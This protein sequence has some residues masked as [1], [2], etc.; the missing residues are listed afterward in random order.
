[1]GHLGLMKTKHLVLFSLLAWLEAVLALLAL[2][3]MVFTPGRGGTF[4]Y[5]LMRQVLSAGW[6]VFLLV[7]AIFTI[8]LF[9]RPRWGTVLV[10]WLDDALI[11]VKKRLFWVQFWL[12]LAALFLFECFLI[13]Y[14][15]FPE[16]A[17]P[18]L[19]WATLLCA[20]AWVALR[21]VYAGEY[22]SR[23]SLIARI[24]AK[25]HAWMPIQ[26]KTFI[27]L[28]ILS[29]IYFAAFI[30]A[31]SH[32]DQSGNFYVHQD[33]QVVYPEVV[34]DMVFPPTVS[35]M[36]H[37]VLEGWGWQY[38]YPYFTASAAVLLIPRLVYGP[39]FAAHIRLNLFLL[40]QFIDVLPMTLAILLVV[41][42]ATRFKNLWASV[43]AF[44]FMALL[45][46]VVKYNIRFY[47]PDALIVL[48]MVLGIYGL[49]KDDLR[50]GRYFYL[51][52][53]CCGLAA[54]IK[55][56]GLFFGPL[57][58]A[59]LLAGWIKKRLS[60]GGL[61]VKGG[62][63]VLAMLA[64]AVISTPTL[65]APYIARVALRSWL[66]RQGYLLTGYPVPDPTGDYG[67]GLVNW[68]RFF[69]AHYMKG[70]YF[71]FSFLALLAG[72]L[73]GSRKSLNR[74]LLGLC[75]VIAIFLAYVVA[76]KNLQYMLPLAL[77]L[78]A[79]AFLFPS[80]AEPGPGSNRPVF[81]ARPL[82]ARMIQMVT[83]C[84]VISQ[85][86][87]NLVILGLFIIRGQ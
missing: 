34:K 46:G 66:P 73:W 20:Q 40:R 51:A 29:L 85:F 14:L 48:L 19:L 52:A 31:N 23:P 1:M 57:I 47:H 13:T 28:A 62:L 71:Y 80:V 78:S 27:V 79:A 54:V 5:P 69:G 84:M 49:H 3:G 68:L 25:W 43:G 22:R 2:W 41:Y 42:L 33:E 50:F 63:F 17:R 83:I 59:Y 74:I 81:L 30:P 67:K 38:G 64:A 8:G 12:I 32:V 75:A 55:L 11:G 87:I 35:G 58:G 18:F 39:A 26:R 70:Y 45:P 86:V 36:V 61:F 21:L 77:P 16:P 56:W 82:T 9:V 37:T 4:S 44:L 53:V 60:L 7:L 65:M 15:A 6:I 72:S 24:S 76:L 10:S